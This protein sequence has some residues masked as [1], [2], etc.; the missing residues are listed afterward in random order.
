MFI[1]DNKIGIKSIEGTKKSDIQTNLLTIFDLVSLLSPTLQQKVDEYY[2]LKLDDENNE[3]LDALEK[4][5]DKA[6]VGLPIHDYR[7]FLFLKFLK[8]R[9]L[10]PFE[11]V[12]KVEV[13]EMTDEEFAKF[14]EEYKKYL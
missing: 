12:E 2:K 1:H 6:M 8:K 7:Y 10:N 14:E 3:K 9:G 13:P 11:A 5:L 4:E